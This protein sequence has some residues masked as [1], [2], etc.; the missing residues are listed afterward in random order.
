MSNEEPKKYCYQVTFDKAWGLPMFIYVVAESME[1][2][3]E[4]AEQKK[5]FQQK[6][7]NC[8]FMGLAP[9]I[10]P[11]D[12]IL[13]KPGITVEAIEDQY[14]IGEK[15]L[16]TLIYYVYRDAEPDHDKRNILKFSTVSHR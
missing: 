14:I 6:I 15:Q 1:K 7:E 13:Q 5:N 4:Y 8:K 10:S 11:V 3:C 16:K 9:L 2:A 12:I